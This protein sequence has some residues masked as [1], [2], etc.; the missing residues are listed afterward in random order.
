MHGP[1]IKM[2]HYAMALLGQNVSLCRG[3]FPRVHEYTYSGFDI[4]CIQILG[5]VSL[6]RVN[7]SALFVYG[8]EIKQTSVDLM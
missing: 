4:M 6:H 7:T 1:L 8:V 2:D 5:P 3:S